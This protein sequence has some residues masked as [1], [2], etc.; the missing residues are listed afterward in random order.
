[1]HF[2]GTPSLVY[3]VA[4]TARVSATLE[5]VAPLA[6]SRFMHEASSWTFPQPPKFKVCSSLHERSVRASSTPQGKL[7]HGCRKCRKEDPWINMF[8]AEQE[9]ITPLSTNAPC[10][11][12]HTLSCETPHVIYVIHCK[13]CNKQGVGETEYLVRGPQNTYM[14]AGASTSGHATSS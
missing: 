12:L 4:N 1:M 14:R 9:S 8:L 13:K 11:I 6:M 7:M 10:P 3:Y 2:D 5:R